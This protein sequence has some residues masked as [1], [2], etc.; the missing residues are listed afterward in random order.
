M[1][2]EAVEMEPG[3]LMALKAEA[4]LVEE[5]EEEE[6]DLENMGRGKRA[7]KAVDYQ[8]LA[9]EEGLTFQMS[10]DDEDDGGKGEWKEGDKEDEDFTS[11]KFFGA[12]AV[13]KQMRD[14]ERRDLERA[15][16]ASLAEA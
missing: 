9:E 1:A 11:S 10:D 3:E 14:K 15:L 12:M 2:S 6:E 13:E 5:A 7:R 16:A 8:R 4:G